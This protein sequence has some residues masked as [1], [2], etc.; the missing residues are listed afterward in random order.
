MSE[1]PCQGEAEC[2]T[3]APL[4]AAS[5]KVT[6]GE[7][8][9]SLHQEL[10]VEGSLGLMEILPQDSLPSSKITLTLGN[11][12]MFAVSLSNGSVFMML[13]KPETLTQTNELLQ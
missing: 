2:G 1:L 9:C 7:S 3:T 11:S 10:E 6:P 5:T 12:R 13:P 8:P 4:Q